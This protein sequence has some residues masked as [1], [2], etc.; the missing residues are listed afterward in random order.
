MPETNLVFNSLSSVCQSPLVFFEINIIKLIKIRSSG[1]N[2]QQT[3]LFSK[4]FNFVSN[5]TKHF[6]T[7]LA[8]PQLEQTSKLPK[9]NKHL[10][11]VKVNLNS[12]FC[13]GLSLGGD[14][15]ITSAYFRATMGFLPS[16]FFKVNYFHAKGWAGGHLSSRT[17]TKRRIQI[18]LHTW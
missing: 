16:F 4:S 17:S 18:N 8:N 10:P 3:K 12:S 2:L 14:I 6:T 5:L 1:N 13:G 7:L 15:E 9:S 11:S